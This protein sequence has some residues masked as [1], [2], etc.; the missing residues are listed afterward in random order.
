LYAEA[1]D[2]VKTLS[3]DTVVFPTFQLEEM[4]GLLP[5]GDPRPPQWNLISRFVP[6]LDLIALSTYPGLVFSDP[7]RLPLEYLRRA[8]GYADVPVAIAEMGFS[9]EPRG[10]ASDGE[11]PQTAFLERMLADAER[12][13]MPLIVWF[14]GRDPNF[15]GGQGFDLLRHLGLLRSDGSQKPVWSLWEEAA[16]QPL[17]PRDADDR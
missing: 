17:A 8:Q 7:S 6:K 16:Q 2:A 12:L 11:Q 10:G 14:V 13:E 5:P 15:T 1:Y 4:H 3:A 9:S